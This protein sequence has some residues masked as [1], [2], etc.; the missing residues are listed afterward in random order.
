MNKRAIA[1]DAAYRRRRGSVEDSHAIWMAH[2]YHT[3]AY[4]ALMQ[5][6]SALADQAVAEMGAALSELEAPPGRGAAFSDI[7]FAMPFEL[8]LRFG[9][10]DAMLAEPHP[11]ERAPVASALWRFA[12][13]TAFAAKKDT[14]NCA[15][16][17]R[18]FIASVDIIESDPELRKH[19]GRNALPVAKQML[20]G[21][22]L[23]REG[24]V[25]AA[26]AILRKAVATEDHLPFQQPPLL[27]LHSRHVLGAVLLD[28]GLAGEGEVVYREDLVRHPKNFWSLTGLARSLDMQSKIAEA[29]SVNAELA[30]V[31]Q[32]ADVRVSSSCCCLPTRQAGHN[33]RETCPRCK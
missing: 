26:L 1:V 30:A 28:C 3:L 31:S 11:P 2:D 33:A 19:S 27:M 4:A 9:R 10:W 7:F 29:T 6:Q 32:Q 24:N 5:G 15:R 12:R 16:Q 13:A 21:E 22:I 14:V 18:A 23:Y 8:H 17:Q 20:Q 25:E